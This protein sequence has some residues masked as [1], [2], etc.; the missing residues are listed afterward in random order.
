MERIR[1]HSGNFD[2]GFK[3]NTLSVL[4]N[5]TKSVIAIKLCFTFTSTSTSISYMISYELKLSF[6]LS[7]YMQT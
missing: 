3:K 6:I 7:T 4:C 5:P 2:V 1:A